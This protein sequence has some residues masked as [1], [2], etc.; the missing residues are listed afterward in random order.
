[1]CHTGGIFRVLADG[2]VPSTEDVDMCTSSIS[3]ERGAAKDKKHASTGMFLISVCGRCV[4]ERTVLT[5]KH[6]DGGRG[7][8]WAQQE[9]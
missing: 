3:G 9:R 6:D 4:E 7:I 2:E 8:R 5:Q 1:M